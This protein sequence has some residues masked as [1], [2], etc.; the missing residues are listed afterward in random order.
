MD[1]I[2]GR[3]NGII[4]TIEELLVLMSLR[5]RCTRY[6]L[7]ELN[8]V[9]ATTRKKRLRAIITAWEIIRKKDYR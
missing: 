6:K 2:Q 1:D 9:P 4:Q 7:S 5:V 8:E 3:N